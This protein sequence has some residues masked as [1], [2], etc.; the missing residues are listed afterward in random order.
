MTVAHMGNEQFVRKEASDRSRLTFSAS[1]VEGN[2][3]YMVATVDSSAS[4]TPA[5][6]H[7]WRT[8]LLLS[9]GRTAGYGRLVFGV[10]RRACSDR[11]MVSGQLRQSLADYVGA[12]WLRGWRFRLDGAQPR[13]PHFGS[14]LFHCIIIDGGNGYRSDSGFCHRVGNR[15]TITLSDR[16]LS[17][18]AFIRS[19]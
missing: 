11:G 13:R 2:Q 17:G 15:N 5:L 14:P 12:D 4:T 7:K 9:L 16:T 6:R 18:G 8:L 1:E 19:E 10:S 3:L